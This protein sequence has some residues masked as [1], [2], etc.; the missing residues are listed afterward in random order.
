MSRLV[1]VSNRIADLNNDPVQ[2]GGLAVALVDAL[3]ERGGV[4]FGWN[5]EI[6]DRKE[7]AHVEQYGSITK[8]SLSLTKKDYSDYYLGYANG[9]LWPL[10]HYRLDLVRYRSSHFSGYNR[11][12]RKFAAA[13]MPHLKFDDIIWAQDYH[14]ITFARSLR[15]LG[16]R[17]RIGFFLHIPFPPPDLLAASSNHAELV[18]AL[19]AYDVIGMQTFLD[20]N[21]FKRYLTDHTDAEVLE[22]GDVRIGRR[23]IKV[24]RFPIGMDVEAFGEMSQRIT[25]DVAVDIKRREVLGRKQ[26]IGVDRLDYSKGLPSRVKA[27]GRMLAKY[28]EMEKAVTFLQIAPPTREAVDAYSDIRDE[29]EALTGSVNGKYSDFNWTPI[30]YIHRSVPRNKLAALFRAS[31]AGFVTPLRDG[32]NL[33]AKEYVAAQN[34]EDPGVLVLSQ[35]A[36]AAEEMQEALIVNPYDI[37]EMADKLYAALTMPLNERKERHRALLEKIQRFDAKSWLVGFLKILEGGVEPVPKLPKVKKTPRPS[38]SLT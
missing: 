23:T 36:G 18:Q 20:V 16:C 37:D 31:Q 7:N 30:R 32:M 27:F 33:V 25:D 34:P 3:R 17:Q 38:A 11:V 35:F 10:F 6:V 22:N 24:E 21:N 1:I 13:L 29:M 9:V 26:I 5:G 15:N 14:L 28:P 4:W 2:Q 19:M 12:N 8:I